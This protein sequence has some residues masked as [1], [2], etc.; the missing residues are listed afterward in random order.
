[1]SWVQAYLNLGL[2]HWWT[3]KHA[4]TTTDG[5]SA[6]IGEYIRMKVDFINMILCKVS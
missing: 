3:Q 4:I 2:V 1:M 5:K 6:K